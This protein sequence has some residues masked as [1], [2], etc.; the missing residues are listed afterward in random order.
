M[1][2]L[3]LL[4]K[5]IRTVLRNR[6]ELLWMIIVPLILLAANF[7]LQDQSMEVKVALVGDQILLPTLERRVQEAEASQI[8]LIIWPLSEVEAAKRLEEG[9]I[10]AYLVLH[11]REITMYTNLADTEGALAQALFTEIVRDSNQKLALANLTQLV[12]NPSA[13]LSPIDWQ[14]VEAST[15]VSSTG[16]LIFSSLFVIMGVMT[17]LSLG[18]QSISMERHK[19]TLVSLRKSPLTDIQIV[20]AKLGAGLFST[21]LPS[22]AIIGLTAAILPAE[23]ASDPSF[24]IILLSISFN[25]VALGVLIGSFV[26]GSNEG[27]GLR[28]LLALPAMFLAA[29]PVAL[30]LWLERISG[31]VP[32]LISAQMVR[33]YFADGYTPTFG[34]VAFLILTGFLSVQLAARYLGREE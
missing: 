6:R 33:G 7:Y 10:H 27:N 26:R 9:A 21:L 28:F 30:P 4:K 23:F 2:G 31:I 17:A 1:K 11:P 8:R 32:T 12:D 20:W 5:D 3:V 19:N 29:V 13:I 14:V 24:Y 18:Q 16:E 22:L 25:S 34:P 15:R